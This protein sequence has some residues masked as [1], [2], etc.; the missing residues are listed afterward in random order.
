MKPFPSKGNTRRNGKEEIIGYLKSL[1][2]SPYLDGD[3][4]N[5]ANFNVSRVLEMEPY[6]GILFLLDYEFKNWDNPDRE[7]GDNYVISLVK[8]GLFYWEDRNLTFDHFTTMLRE[9]HQVHLYNTT[10]RQTFED[11]IS[12]A[13]ER[14]KAFSS[15]KLKNNFS[16]SKISFYSNTFNRS[17]LSTKAN[18]ELS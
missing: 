8:E 12:K 3:S 14:V 18:R 6:Y 16:S 11:D 2:G 10:Y 9:M 1:G 13:V 7:N 4:W 5:P 15:V 17:S